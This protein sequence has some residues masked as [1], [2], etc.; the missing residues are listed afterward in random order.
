MTQGTQKNS[1]ILLCLFFLGHLLSV[2][3]YETSIIESS[4]FFWVLLPIMSILGLFAYVT[5]LKMIL[6]KILLLAL[7]DALIL[8]I[9]FSYIASQPIAG[10]SAVVFVIY[11]IMFAVAQTII[12]SVARHKLK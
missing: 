6:Y 12:T 5:S 10:I 4:L 2:S 7:I 1:F 11:I 3:L 8:F 9:E